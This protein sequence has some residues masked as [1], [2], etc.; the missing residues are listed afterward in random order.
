[1]GRIRTIK[2]EFTQDEE[3]STLHCETHLFAAGLLCYADDFG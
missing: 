2:P 3:L 1:M